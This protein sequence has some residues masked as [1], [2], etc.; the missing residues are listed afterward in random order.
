MCIYI[1]VETL[2]IMCDTRHVIIYIC[3]WLRYIAHRLPLLAR[4]LNHWVHPPAHMQGVR[5]RRYRRQ[6]GYGG[7]G[8]AASGVTGAAVPPPTG[9]RGRRYRRQ[10][11]YTPAPW[12]E[13]GFFWERQVSHFLASPR[14][15]RPLLNFSVIDRFSFFIY[16]CWYQKHEKCLRGMTGA[17][18]YRYI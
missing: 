5:G 10:R 14:L 4:H 2:C 18:C 7:G 1:C 3:I 11:G 16:R 12:S 6:L 8:T 13:T 17:W 9:V 15:S